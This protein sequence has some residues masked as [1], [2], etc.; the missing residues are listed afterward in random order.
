MSAFG[1]MLLALAITL[2]IGKWQGFTLT[3]TGYNR[4]KGNG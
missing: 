2:A 1:L 3:R 4:F